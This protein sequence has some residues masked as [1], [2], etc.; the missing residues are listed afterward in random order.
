M[1]EQ[2]YDANGEAIPGAFVDR[3][4]DGVIT[5]DDRYYRAVIPN[6]TFGFGFNFTYKQW[7]FSSNFRGQLGGQIYNARKLT[8]GW[9]DKAIPTNSS[10]L[11]NVLDFYNDAADIQ[12]QNYNGNATFSD[13]F[14][15][16]ATFLR[17]ENIV[18]G[19]RF[20]KFYKNSS[21]RVYGAINN[22]FILTQNFDSENIV[23]EQEAFFGFIPSITFNFKF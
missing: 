14:L 7:D 3:N 6:W 1:F 23:L 11:S 5:N 9:V 18:L 16:D 13:Y 22:P 8:S 2:L 21:M 15:E 19:Y 12:F 20:N 17:C 10:S 4:A